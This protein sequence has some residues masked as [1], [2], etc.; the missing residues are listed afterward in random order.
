VSI[1]ISE[2]HSFR[3]LAHLAGVGAVAVA[4]EPPAKVDAHANA[5]LIPPM[6]RQVVSASI[7]SELE[8]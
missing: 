3:A 4:E 5:P 2:K 1:T 6:S 8:W 7:A